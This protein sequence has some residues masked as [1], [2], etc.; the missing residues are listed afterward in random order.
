MFAIGM[1]GLVLGAFLIDCAV[2]GRPP[3]DT[4]RGLLLDP[5]NAAGVL[6]ENTGVLTPAV[7]TPSSSE[8]VAEDK[9]AFVDASFSGGGSS[10][11]TGSAAKVIAYATKQLGK[12][13]RWG[14]IGP[15]TFDCSGLTMRAYE[16]VGISLGRTTYQQVLK[17]RDVKRADMLPGDLI[18]PDPGHVQIYTGGNSI[19]EAPRTGLRVRR[20]VVTRVWKVRRV[21]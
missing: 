2:Q 16:Q 6:A 5:S 14:G 7:Y 17:G 3:L 13:Y 18:F 12:P 11:A 15:D 19:I 21:L 1:V 8:T 10:T 4:L 9:G 20:S